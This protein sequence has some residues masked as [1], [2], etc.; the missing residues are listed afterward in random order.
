M[1]FNYYISKKNKTLI[2]NIIFLIFALIFLLILYNGVS[3]FEIKILSYSLILMLLY[4]LYRVRKNIYLF[5]IFSLIFYFNYSIIIAN[6]LKVNPTNYFATFSNDHVSLLGMYILYIFH[7]SLILFLPLEINR[8]K[9]RLLSSSKSNKSLILMIMLLSVLVYILIT[10]FKIPQISGLRGK[11]SPLYEYSIIF[12]I[13]G[14]YF[15]G[16]IKFY[17]YLLTI[18]LI[19]YILQDFFFGGRI[20]GLQ[21][22]LMY[23][24]IFYAHNIKIIK[25]IPFIVSG[26]IILSI[27]GEY[28]GDIKLSLNVINNI[29]SELFEKM[30][31]LDTA[32]SAYFTSLTF[33]KV[34]E[35]TSFSEVINLFK[36]FVITMIVGGRISN[37]NLPK[38]TSNY[39]THYGGGLLPFYF[40]FY[41]SWIGVLLSSFLISFY[42]KIIN[43]IKKRSKGLKKCVMVY[44]VATVFR[45]YL[46]SPSNLLRG[47]ILMCLTYFMSILIMNFEKLVFNKFS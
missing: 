8:E 42:I 7:L 16:K 30:F 22:I 15:F 43:N 34:K 19:L 6:Y 40:Y 23:F 25:V 41:L 5:L 21:L 3:F 32:Y 11:A 4:L 10:Q 28:R 44:I 13:I 17:R 29:V 1:L 14:F 38:Y 33:L 31:A 46:Y 18:L 20:T 2:K 39:I 24:I 12:F 9:K 27:I 37:H 47:I 35:L 36:K 26:F 45:W